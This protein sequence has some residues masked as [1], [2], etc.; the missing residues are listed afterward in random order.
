MINMDERHDLPEELDEA[1]E[2]SLDMIRDQI[3]KP[4]VYDGSAQY[5]LDQIS[6]YA[7]MSLTY[8]SLYYLKGQKNKATALMRHADALE[9]MINSL[10]YKIKAA[11]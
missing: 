4:D 6:A 8:S 10:K 3:H 1:I 2:K 5:S 9:Y 11:G 7:A